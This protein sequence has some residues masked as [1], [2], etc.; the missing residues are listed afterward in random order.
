MAFHVLIVCTAN[1]CRSPLA[2]GYLDKLLGERGARGVDVR[3]AGTSFAGG[4]PA[5]HNSRL[6]ALSNGFDI[7]AHSST[8]IDAELCD[9]ADDILVMSER[10]RLEIEMFFPGEAEEKV[11]LLGKFDPHYRSGRSPSAEIEDPVG[12]E[13]EQYERVFRQ[14]KRALDSYFEE[15][16]AGS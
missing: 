1:I 7:D 2:H 10:H 11:K 5:S 3:S 9:W 8:R 12:A 4:Y 6:V 16:I 13:I 14:I 15:R